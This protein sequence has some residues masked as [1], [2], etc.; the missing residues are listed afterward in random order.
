MELKFLWGNAIREMQ[1]KTMMSYHFTR[2]RMAIIKRPLTTRV[3][4]EV[5]QLEP[6]YITGGNV[7]QWRPFGKQ[8]G[9]SLKIEHRITI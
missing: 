3:D 4:Q 1:T 2:S 5:E 9:S 6:S 7:R 8:S